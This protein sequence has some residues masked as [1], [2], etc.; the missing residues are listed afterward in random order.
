[1]TKTTIA[2]G[3]P[4][5]TLPSAT[6]RGAQADDIRIRVVPMSR[7][8]IILWHTHVQAAVDGHYEH[9]TENADERNVRADVGWNWYRIATLARLHDV[10]ML[11]PGNLS[12]PALA[13]CI[14]VLDGDG[15]LFPIGMLTVVPR[16]HCHVMGQQGVRTFTW[17]LADAPTE[18]Y[19]DVLQTSFRVRGVATAL[20]DTAI[21]SGLDLNT[22]GS[23]LLH[24]D[25]KA[26]E[27]LV[28]FYGQRCGMTRL[29]TGDPPVSHW[30]R[31][32]T[33]EYFLLDA[34][35]SR[36]FA[37]KYEGRRLIA[38]EASL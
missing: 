36:A 35:Q 30:R 23:V 4:I 33:E 10:A 37:A 28:K 24:A 22:D 21:Q 2:I 26:G 34:G 5:K 8:L 1:M 19:D 20:I 3:R 32:H 9:W 25:P 27:K 6:P 15:R 31:G 13:W 38:D 14:A 12:G 29:A 17:F 11:V 16:F 7:Q 18:V